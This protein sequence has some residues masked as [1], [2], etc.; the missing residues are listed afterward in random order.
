[1][2]EKP[3]PPDS[4]AE[5]T[6]DRAAARTAPVSLRRHLLKE[7]PLILLVS[8]LTL[9]LWFS[10]CLQ[11]QEHA[12]LDL[13]QYLKKQIWPAQVKKVTIVKI[14]NDE[15]Y[16]PKLFDGRCPLDPERLKVLIGAIALGTPAL[17]AV[18]IDTRHRDFSRLQPDPN[19]PPIVWAQH[20]KAAPL[21]DCENGQAIPEPIL[22]DQNLT[23]SPLRGL[24]IFPEDHDRTIRHY[25][26]SCRTE[27]GPRPLFPAAVAAAWR[28]LEAGRPPQSL[29]QSD[30]KP[31]EAELDFLLD[32]TF[33]HQII[34]A[35]QVF[36]AAGSGWRD[37]G[38]LNQR[39]VLLGGEYDERSPKTSLKGRSLVELIADAIEGELQEKLI[40][41]VKWWAL[42][43]SLPV[44]GYLTAI[45]R[46]HLYGTRRRIVIW[47]AIPVIAMAISLVA[48]GRLHL[49]FDF[50]PVMTAVQLHQ[51]L[52]RGWRF[53]RNQF[54]RWPG[55][56]Q[57]PA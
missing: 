1:M 33:D 22:A 48:F 26:R 52:N 39:I 44:A 50:V 42:A 56:R 8:L 13:N 37:D 38:P 4:A 49:S 7:T 3:S 18:A 16:D 5:T 20:L 43:L 54:N 11:R 6:G 30:L 27:Y 41:P 51:P 28:Q 32:T 19:W 46:F 10:G 21:L 31:D 57:R 24:N 15:Y 17:I 25:F 14:T 53:L 12:V 29:I 2:S 45:L 23:P 9:S 36:E 55:N 47:P 34:K 40:R 35:R